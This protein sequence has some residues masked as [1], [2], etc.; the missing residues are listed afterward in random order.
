MYIVFLFQGITHA[1]IT[2]LGII[3]SLA[4]FFYDTRIRPNNNNTRLVN[5]DEYLTTDYTIDNLYE[6][7][8]PEYNALQVAYYSLPFKFIVDF[9]I[10]QNVLTDFDD[11]TKKL[12][13]AHFDNELFMNASKRILQFRQIIINNIRDVNEDLTN[14][15]QILGQSL[16]TLQ[17]FYSHS[18]WIEMGKT[19]INELIGFNEIIGSVAR[20]NQATCTNNGCTKIE[21]PCTLWEKIT[22][23]ICPL[24]Y[25]D[26]KNNILPEINNQQLLTSGYTGNGLSENNEVLEKPTNVEKCSHGGVL[27]ESSH[28]PAVGGINK[29]SYS[30]VFSPHFDLHKQAVDLAIKATEQFLNDLRRDIGDENFDRFFIIN[31]T[32]AQCQIASDSM[33]QGK[34]FRFFRGNLS[35]HL[36]DDDRWWTK[37]KRSFTNFFRLNKSIWTSDFFKEETINQPTFDLS[38]QGVNVKDVNNFRAAPYVIGKEDVRR[39]KRSI[40]LARKHRYL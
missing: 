9:I 11:Q 4:R 29:D 13:E 36:K 23:G 24:V 16:H 7:A 22:V 31:P 35:A 40:D 14:A 8:Y 19:D 20:P 34:R 18:N 33:S 25:Y 39:K 38:D 30:F 6:L 37:L 17:D 26:C 10:T 3:R 2:E 5:E 27:D 12:S 28:T 15:R 21:K 1:D 32:E